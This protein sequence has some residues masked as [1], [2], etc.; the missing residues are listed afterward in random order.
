MMVANNANLAHPPLVARTTEI[1]DPGDLL[2][3]LP[4]PDPDRILAWVRGGMGVIGIGEAMRITTGGGERFADADGAFAELCS[5]SRIRDDVGRPGTG[6]IAFGSFAF[7][8]HSTAGGVLIIPQVVLGKD[9]EGAWLTTISVEPALV[10]P[11]LAD[12]TEQ[13]EAER[14]TVNVEFLGGSLERAAWIAEVEQVMERI[15]EGEAGK[16]VLARDS[17]ARFDAP[18]DARR[19]L[20]QL[21]GE[22]PSC[23]S[24]AVDGFFGATPEL[25]ARRHKG[26]ISS[27]VLAGTIRRSGDSKEDTA[28]AAALAQDSKELAEHAYA[29]DSLVDSLRPFAASFSVPDAPFILHLPNVMHLATDVTASPDPGAAGCSSLALAAKFHPTA[30]VCGTPTPVAAGILAEHERLDRHRYAG[31][32]G[33]IGAN[34]DGE[35]GI[36]LRCGRAIDDRNWQIYAGCGI[37]SDSRP[38]AEWEETEAKFAPMRSALREA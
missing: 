37:M 15:R 9:S 2:D 11:T 6:L 34:G 14:P 27:R 1:E 35:W 5:G 32:V 3:Y 13:V 7:S 23:W 10:T 33:W 22:Y 31:P 17:F 26:L 38:E 20:R 25:L 24:F 30:A 21:L 19:I 18:G 36:A 29:V 12:L 4:S 16:V 8:R 28:R